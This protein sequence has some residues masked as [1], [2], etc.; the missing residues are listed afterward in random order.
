MKTLPF[1]A[2]LACLCSSVFPVLADNPGELHAEWEVV[3][4]DDFS[5]TELDTDKWGRI[6]YV[7]W[8]VSDWR[9]YQS[10]DPS[11]VQANADTGTLT[12]WGRYGDYESQAHHS[13][14]VAEGDPSY[15]C[16]GITTQNTFTFRQGYVEV[17]ARFDCADG[18]WPAIWLM[19]VSGPWPQTGEIDIMEHLNYQGTILQTIHYANAQGNDAS[20]STNPSWTD[21]NVK[22]QWHTYGMEWTEDAITFYL[23]GE[24][25]ARFTAEMV[26][27]AYWPF[28]ADAEE[29]YILIDQQIGGN[30]VTDNGARAINQSLLSTTGAGFELDYVKVYSTAQY[31]SIPEPGTAAL[32]VLA[33]VGVAWRRRRSTGCRGRTPR[34]PFHS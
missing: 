26:G 27:E 11:L 6:P 22:L 31:A 2:S 18:V 5:G 25:T 17:R 30:W 23:D 13:G 1:L 7:N 4:E 29:F 9:V 3:F 34:T 19:P 10:Q 8:G 15:A 16:G 14:V 32:G 20:R 24:Q 12:L 21:P 28:G 33:L